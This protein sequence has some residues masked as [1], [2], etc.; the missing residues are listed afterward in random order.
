MFGDAKERRASEREGCRKRERASVREKGQSCLSIRGIGDCAGLTYDNGRAACLFSGLSVARPPTPGADPS[1]A[2]QGISHRAQPERLQR[3]CNAEA[4]RIRHR[5][6]CVPY[7]TVLHARGQLRPSPPALCH[8][9]RTDIRRISAISQRDATRWRSR[10][11]AQTSL[12]V[13]T[14]PAS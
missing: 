10:T 3:L 8:R 12:M 6:L 7:S 5:T 14:S 9:G 13:P 11:Q 4:L 2:P 1:R